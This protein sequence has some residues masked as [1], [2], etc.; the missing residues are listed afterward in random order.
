MQIQ[1]NL[2]IKTVDIFP[3]N[4]AVG[5]VMF[6]ELDNFKKS[7]NCSDIPLVYTTYIICTQ[8]ITS[9]ISNSSLQHLY[10]EL[11]L[12]VSECA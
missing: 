2:G 7:Y 4:T 1:P 11:M 10:N 6:R 5:D 8:V 12:H 3:K 9:T